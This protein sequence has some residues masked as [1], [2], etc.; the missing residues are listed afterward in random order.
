MKREIFARTVPPLFRMP[1]CGYTTRVS[2]KTDGWQFGTLGGIG[3]SLRGWDARAV[4]ETNE[5]ASVF[6]LEDGGFEP[7]HGDGA[8]GGVFN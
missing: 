2:I 1:D 6:F 8:S 4:E 7:F 3:L 5:P